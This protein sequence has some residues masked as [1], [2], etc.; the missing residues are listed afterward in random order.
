M[1]KDFDPNIIKSLS[2][3]AS[4]LKIDATDPTN[5][6]KKIV[7][8]KDTRAKFLAEARRMGCEKEMFLLLS[9]YDN[10]MRNCT[11]DKERSDISKLGCVE[12]YK[13]LGGG[14]ELY[15]DGQL[16]VKDN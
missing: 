9:K 10:L 1:S 6:S 16:V 7:S 12:V 11:N 4:D 5:L 13:L 8:E 15:V 3:S 2:I 14:G